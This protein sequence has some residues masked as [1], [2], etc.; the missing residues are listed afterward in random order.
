MA[1][2]VVLIEAAPTPWDVEGRLVGD[3]SLP[4]TAEALD[5]IRHLLEGI[6]EPIAAV[7]R[8]ARNDA[9]NDAA[10]LIGKKFGLR[11][12]DNPDLDEVGL[13]LWQGLLPDDIR[14]RFP[15]VFPMWEEQPLQ[16]NPPDG[17]PLQLAVERIGPAVRQIV[18]RNRGSAIALA[19]RPMA[20]Q[21]AGGTL[22]NASLQEIAV[23]LRNRQAIERI[24]VEEGS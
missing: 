10:R 19:L 21:I 8:P 4:L 20:L 11:L 23:R 22:R 14:H 18:R 5:S 13:G 9:C 15:T 17:E 3:S 7:Y 16:V 24:D 2:R 1:T 6:S 12:R